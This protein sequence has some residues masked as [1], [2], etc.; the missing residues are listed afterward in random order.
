[1]VNL[2]PLRVR[3]LQR[4]EIYAPQSYDHL[5]LLQLHVIAIGTRTIYC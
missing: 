2:L 1:M 5:E 4:R 3:W